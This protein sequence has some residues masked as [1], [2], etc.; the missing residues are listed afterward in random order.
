MFA[1]VFGFFIIAVIV[2]CVLTL[3]WAIQRDRARRAPRSPEDS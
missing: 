3:R 1:A 2:L